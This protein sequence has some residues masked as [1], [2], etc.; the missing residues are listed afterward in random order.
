MYK[1]Y[2]FRHFCHPAPP[3]R[4]TVDCPKGQGAAV[5]PRRRSRSAAPCGSS[6]RWSRRAESGIPFQIHSNSSIQKVAPWG[7]RPL[8]PVPRP[9]Q[10]C[11]VLVHIPSVFGPMMAPKSHPRLPK[12]AKMTHHGPKM[13]A[14]GLRWPLTRLQDGPSGLQDG[15][16][17]AQDASRGAPGGQNC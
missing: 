6:H 8:P 14:D 13:V 15:P 7:L 4:S 5:I 11:P 1:P 16:G 9:I 3:G 2:V 10:S 12:M 17:D